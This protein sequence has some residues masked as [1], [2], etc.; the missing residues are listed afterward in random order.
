LFIGFVAAQIDQYQVVIIMGALTQR[1]TSPAGALHRRH[2]RLGCRHGQGDI[3]H[4]A[5]RGREH[6]PRRR[7]SQLNRMSGW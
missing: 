2:A 4:Q 6:P 3:E 5:R 1:H 7:R